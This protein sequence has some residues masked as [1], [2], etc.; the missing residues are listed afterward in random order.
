MIKKHAGLWLVLGIAFLWASALFYSIYPYPSRWLSD[1]VSYLN[2]AKHIAYNGT[3]YRTSFYFENDLEEMRKLGQPKPLHQHILDTHFPAYSYFLSIFLL[4]ADTDFWGAY[5]AHTFMLL[6]IAGLTYR[7]AMNFSASPKVAL[8]SSIAVVFCPTLSTFMPLTLPEIYFVFMALVCVFFALR[9]QS[10][11]NNIYTSLFLTLL[12]LSR[13]NFMVLAASIFAVYLVRFFQSREQKILHFISILFIVI[14][15]ITASLTVGRSGWL[16][17]FSSK[18][19]IHLFLLDPQNLLHVIGTILPNFLRNISVAKSHFEFSWVWHPTNELYMYGTIAI[20][21]CSGVLFRKQPLTWIVVP[22]YLGNAT[23]VMALY[24]WYDWRHIRPLMWGLPFGYIFLFSCINNIKSQ[25]LK[26]SFAALLILLLSY[27][28]YRA[29]SHMHQTRIGEW[30][31]MK[32]ADL[33]AQQIEAYIAAHYPE[34]DFVIVPYKS[35]YALILHNQKRIIR[36]EKDPRIIYDLLKEYEID[37]DIILVPP[38]H[39][40]GF[41]KSPLMA[42]HTAARDNIKIKYESE[43]YEMGVIVNNHLISPGAD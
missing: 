15:P 27:S 1:D 8:L 2:V 17:F 42:N 4:I 10:V 31:S 29:N 35:M 23:G 24:D 34:T 40:G 18:T 43:Q 3:P 25:H 5:L 20:I 37:K 16:W 21:A 13:I 30:N 41:L 38:Q 33:V 28:S 22:A 12:V 9:P 7:I 14:L 19:P 32:R 11:S 6:V 26:I 39:M 36:P